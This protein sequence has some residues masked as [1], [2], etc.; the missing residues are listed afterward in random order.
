MC[1][2]PYL[3]VNIGKEGE[4]LISPT[5]EEKRKLKISKSERLKF[6]AFEEDPL[7]QVEL[8]FADGDFGANKTKETKKLK[9]TEETKYSFLLKPLKAEECIL[10]VVISYVSSVPVP[11]TIIEKVTIEKKITPEGGPDTIEES[12]Q[13]TIKP[14]SA[15]TMVLEVKTIDL[16]ISVKMFFNMNAREIEFAKKALSPVVA[17][18]L[19]GV[20][21]YTGLIERQDFLIG[22]IFSVITAAGIT[23]AD[24]SKEKL[25]WLKTDKPDDS[26]E[27]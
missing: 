3:D 7:V 17:A 13:A 4:V 27:V 1:K 18:I 12:E 26:V 25:P 9:K 14:E 15:E 21:L 10:T 11:D 16:L 8:K 22:M 23:I 6:E 19:L 2:C 20:A 24:E 5:E